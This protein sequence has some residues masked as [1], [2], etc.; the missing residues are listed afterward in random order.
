MFDNLCENVCQLY[1]FTGGSGIATKIVEYSGS[2]R[3]A[4]VSVATSETSASENTIAFS[5]TAQIKSSKV[6]LMGTSLSFHYIKYYLE[7]KKNN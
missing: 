1:L 6:L 4:F 7:L 3:R 2:L 5:Q